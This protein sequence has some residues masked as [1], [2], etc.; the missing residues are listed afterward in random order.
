MAEVYGGKEGKEK[1]EQTVDHKVLNSLPPSTT[2]YHL[3]KISEHEI[4]Q[5]INHMTLDFL[6]KRF[7]ID[8]LKEELNRRK[9]R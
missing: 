1:L 4:R 5:A 9:G 8:E 2:H 7:T 3:S 6:V